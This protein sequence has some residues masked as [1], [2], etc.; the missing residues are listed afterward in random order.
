MTHSEVSLLRRSAWTIHSDGLNADHD[1]DKSSQYRSFSL[2]FAYTFKK[3]YTQ[4]VHSQSHNHC[5]AL[6][7]SLSDSIRLHGA[8]LPR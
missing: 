1:F 6:S 5:V 4:V 8:N 7:F 3:S 2:Y